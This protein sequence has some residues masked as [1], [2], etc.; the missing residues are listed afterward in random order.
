M[1]CSRCGGQMEAQQVTF[2]VPAT[3]PQPIIIENVPAMVCR[4]S[5]D[6]VF[7]DAVTATFERVRDG[8]MQPNGQ[9]YSSVYDY[10][11]LIPRVR[12]N[13]KILYADLTIGHLPSTG[14]YHKDDI[15]VG[16]TSAPFL[17]T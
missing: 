7:S 2:C 11:R 14:D 3:R 16:P 13:L 17:V 8:A 6:E 12:V 10:Q 1:I 15:V 5:G 4:R 9:V